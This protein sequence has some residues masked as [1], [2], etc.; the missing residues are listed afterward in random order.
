MTTADK[1]N[2]LKAETG[3]SFLRLAK[4]TGIG[5]TAIQLWSK[6]GKA[7]PSKVAV[8]DECIRA[9]KDGELQQRIQDIKN[10]PY[11]GDGRCAK[12]SI[13]EELEAEDESILDKLITLIEKLDY[14]RYPDWQDF[15][16]HGEINLR[17]QIVSRAGHQ[18]FRDMLF[19]AQPYK[20]ESNPVKR[21]LILIGDKN[22]IE[23]KVNRLKRCANV[24]IMER[25]NGTR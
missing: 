4:L 21:T 7:I 10:E 20:I 17:A 5:H 12:K 1:V 6:G 3:F 23:R 18:Y 24:T 11:S 14:P 22:S 13:Y 2:W 19:P 16:S 25:S 9:Y 8:L 15:Q